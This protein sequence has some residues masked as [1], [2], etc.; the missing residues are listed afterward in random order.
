MYL[1]SAYAIPHV[2][3]ILLHEP[4]CDRYDRDPNSSLARC[5]T[6]AKCVVGSVH[7]LAGTSND[8]SGIEP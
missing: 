4:F 1:A 5:L 2:A 3:S 8:L 7:V 6:S